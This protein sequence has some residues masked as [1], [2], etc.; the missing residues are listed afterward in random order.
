MI[1]FLFLAVLGCSCAFEYTDQEQEL[2]PEFDLLRSAP[3]PG[4][5]G[6]AQDTPIDL[7]FNQA[8]DPESLGAADIRLFSGIIETLGLSK[9][10]LLSRRVRFSPSTPLRENLQY[11]L[12]LSESIRGIDGHRL[13]HP[14]TFSFSTGAISATPRDP[15]PQ[16]SALDLQGIWN[17]N[18]TGCHDSTQRRAGLD[19]SSPEAAIRSLRGVPSRGWEMLVVHPADHA[20]SYLIR[21]LLGEG[22]FTGFVMPADGPPLP[23]EHIRKIADWIDGGAQ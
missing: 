23:R 14:I 2:T 6:I 5:T 10:D 15:I 17:S 1:R 22:S 4:Q 9:V 20:R 16:L 18:C 11:Q 7:F 13:G 19:L 21:K 3:E 8:P 12:Y